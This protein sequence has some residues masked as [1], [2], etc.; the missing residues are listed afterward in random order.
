MGAQEWG[1]PAGSL[2]RGLI[3]RGPPGVV[4][5][6]FQV[7]LPALHKAACAKQISSLWPGHETSVGGT[8]HTGSSGQ[9]A[10]FPE[11][12]HI[13]RLLS[14][15]GRRGVHPCE[16]DSDSSGLMHPAPPGNRPAGL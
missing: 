9:C 8:R 16:T 15:Q 11:A 6:S 2:P 13:R 12:S 4:T 3:G 14:E 1:R 5:M 7:L 10:L